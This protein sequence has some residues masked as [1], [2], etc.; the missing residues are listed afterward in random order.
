MS[1]VFI[2]SRPMFSPRA[3]QPLAVLIFGS[4]CSS[5]FYCFVRHGFLFS[6]H[7]LEISILVS[8]Q[9]VYY[10]CMDFKVLSFFL[11]PVQYYTI[12]RDEY[13]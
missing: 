9:P 1:S 5:V 7:K 6:W 10:L 12:E 2:L 8:L 3:A 4:G 13:C 11:S